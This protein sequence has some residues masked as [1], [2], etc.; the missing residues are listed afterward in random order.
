[1]KKSLIRTFY[2]YIQ[3]IFVEGD[4]RVLF[5]FEEYNCIFCAV[6]NNF[7]DSNQNQK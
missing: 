7:F 4:F 3:S 1:M 5:E 2:F 6:L